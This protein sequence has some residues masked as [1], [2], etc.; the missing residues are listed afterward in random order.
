MSRFLF[1]NSYS[2]MAGLREST[3]NWKSIKLNP[4]DLGGGPGAID[5][6]CP[7]N[8]QRTIQNAFKGS[9]YFIAISAYLILSH[10]VA[11]LCMCID[12]KYSSEE[13]FIKY[14]N[15]VS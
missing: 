2:N 6:A 11:R 4:P 3:L 5:Q 15:Y 1:C 7:C 8:S 14:K 10:C 9:F 13:I 12:L